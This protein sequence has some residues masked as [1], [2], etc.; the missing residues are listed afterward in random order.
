MKKQVIINVGV[1]GSGKT[2]WSTDYIKKNPNT[3][4][5]N[6]DDIRKTLVGDL[7]G[8]YKRKDLISI[9]NL[10]TEIEQTLLEKTLYYDN[11]VIIDNTHL[12]VK[13]INKIVSTLDYINKTIEVKFKIFDEADS[14]VLK[15]RVANRDDLDLVNDTTYIDKQ[16][17]QLNPIIQYI[18]ENYPDQ[19]LN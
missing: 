7:T 11:N 4:R 10:V 2:T 16:I 12:Q 8:Y 18:K 14:S 1:S 9:E 19:I 3:L 17:K 5:I 13:Y 15:E 6:R